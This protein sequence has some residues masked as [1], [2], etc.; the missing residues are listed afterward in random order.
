MRRYLRLMFLSA[1]VILMM[2]QAAYAGGPEITQ[3]DIDEG[4]AFCRDFPVSLQVDGE[5]VESDVPPVII[6]EKTLIPVK[7]VFESMGADVVWNEDARLVEITMG[8][9]DVKLTIGS[10]TAFVNGA[11][12]AMEVPA[13]IIKSI[14]PQKTTIH[15]VRPMV[16]EK[17]NP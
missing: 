12:A 9:S 17:L 7:A 8:T 14:T 11:Q 10:T 3:K 2:G 4:L 1:A 6:K 16:N 5:R 13:M 15:L